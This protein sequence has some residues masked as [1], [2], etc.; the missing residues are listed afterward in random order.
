MPQNTPAIIMMIEP[1]RPGA[2]HQ[3]MPAVQRMAKTNDATISL[4]SADIENISCAPSVLTA[5]TVVGT[6]ARGGA[7][8]R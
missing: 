6:V 4:R 3:I 1:A 8:P 7:P 2:F 5:E